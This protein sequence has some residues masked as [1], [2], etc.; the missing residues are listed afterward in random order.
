[1]DEQGDDTLSP[2]I[3]LS[4]RIPKGVKLG[5]ENCTEM[6]IRL[7]NPEKNF[8]S[9]HVAGTNGKGSLCANLSA[10]AAKNKLIVGFFSSPH[11]IFVEERARINGRP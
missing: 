1:M 10:L 7:G 11:L 8:P 2:K 9:V 4:D 5:L 3:W 6:L